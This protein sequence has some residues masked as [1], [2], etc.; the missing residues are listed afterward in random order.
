MLNIIAVLRQFRPVGYQPTSL[1]HSG[2]I[3]SPLSL[4]DYAIKI[5]TTDYGKKKYENERK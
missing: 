5:R 2:G 4:Q 3:L 1:S